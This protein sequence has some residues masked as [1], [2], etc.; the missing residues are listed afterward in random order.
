MLMLMLDDATTTPPPNGTVPAGQVT[1]PRV[2]VPVFVVNV[3]CTWT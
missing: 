1:V 2:C 3:A